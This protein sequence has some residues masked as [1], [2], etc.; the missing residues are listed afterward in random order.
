MSERVCEIERVAREH[1][2]RGEHSLLSEN[3]DMYVG[4][5]LEEPYENALV[6]PTIA[7]IIA[8][9]FRRSRDGDR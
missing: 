3:I 9:Q 7:C 1:G 4:A 2:K 5:I 8:D 6:G